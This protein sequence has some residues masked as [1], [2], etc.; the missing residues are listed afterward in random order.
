MTTGSELFSWG[1]PGARGGG[2]GSTGAPDFVRQ[3]RGDVD[4]NW[5]RAD[6]ETCTKCSAE[7]TT[8][9][10]VRRTATGGWSHEN[11]PPEE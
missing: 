2:Q 11:C 3:D 5:S 4:D 8:R 10:F 7:L 6:G 1:E 9:D